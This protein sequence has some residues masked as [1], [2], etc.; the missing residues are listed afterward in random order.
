[1][2]ELIKIILILILSFVFFHKTAFAYFDPGTGAYIIQ[3]F[4]ALF[5][6][7]IFVVFHPI[8]SIKKALEKIREKFSKKKET[9]K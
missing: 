7:I 3:A 5:S 8:D 2:N 4:I 9:K 1:M 6:V